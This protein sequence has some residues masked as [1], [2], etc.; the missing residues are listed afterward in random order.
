M[1]S[2]CLLSVRTLAATDNGS[3]ET[4]QGCP[5]SS[6]TA[7]KIA[8]MMM[9]NWKIITTWNCS[10]LVLWSRTALNLLWSYV[11]SEDITEHSWRCAVGNYSFDV[12]L[13]V[14]FC[15][16]HASVRGLWDCKCIS[17]CP[18][19]PPTLFLII[20]ALLPSVHILS[21]FTQGAAEKTWRSLNWN[22]NTVTLTFVA[23]LFLLPWR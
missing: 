6:L 7:F 11:A 16:H 12:T 19:T 1:F 21:I 23:Q 20:S 13:F 22:N 2:S 5:E 8:L 3:A 15:H 9:I 18:C 4:V 17:W 14:F 10:P